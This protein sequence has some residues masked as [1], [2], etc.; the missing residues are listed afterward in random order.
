M[1]DR[2]GESGG[3]GGVILFLAGLLLGGIIGFVV[4]AVMMMGKVLDDLERLVGRNDR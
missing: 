1:Q 2:K 4:C 3:V